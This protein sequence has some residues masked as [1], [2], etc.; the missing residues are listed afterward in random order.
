MRFVKVPN[1]I[2]DVAFGLD[3]PDGTVFYLNG[4]GQIHREDGPAV[5]SP[6]GHKKWYI[7]GL[8]H[9]LDGPASVNSLGEDWYQN[10]LLHRKDGPAVIHHSHKEW[11]LNGKRHR[12]GGPAIEKSGYEDEE[13]WENGKRHR[14]DGPALEG[15]WSHN[16]YIENRKIGPSSSNEDKWLILKGDILSFLAFD[17]TLTPEMQ[18]YICKTRPDLIHEIPKLHP[19]LKAKYQ[20]ELFLSKADI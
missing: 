13:W 5:E 3:L 4:Q 2:F 8:L 14:I 18:E 7:D 6:E 19:P 11:W 10:G 12:V 9:R 15:V 16:Y 1:S 17:R 20:H